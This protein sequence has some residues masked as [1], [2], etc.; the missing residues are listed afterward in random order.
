MLNVDTDRLNYAE[1]LMPPVHYHLQ[2]AIATTY[3]L[4]L[5][6]LLSIPVALFYSKSPGDRN[7]K[8]DSIEILDAIQ[9]TE[10]IVS[11]FC[12][13]GKIKIPEDYNHLFA[14]LENSVN[15]INTDEVRSSFHP[16]VW[17]LRYEHNDK[18]AI[19]YKIIV[20]SRNL[21]FDRSWDVAFFSDGE[22]KKNI[23]N[24]N[25]ELVDF[26]AFI[27]KQS[28]IEIPKIFIKDL[29]KVEF[30]IPKDVKELF[31]HPILQFKNA[32]FKKQY[33][34]PLEKFDF[35]KLLIISPF[36]DKS[37]LNRFTKQSGEKYLFSRKEE[38][39]KVEK[40]RLDKFT[41][42]YYINTNIVHGEDNI[43][44]ESI[45]NSLQ[46]LHAKVFVLEKDNNYSLY[47][48]SA[49]CSAPAFERNTEFMTELKSSDNKYS[50][51]NIKNTLLNQ[52]KDYQYFFE[53]KS[54]Q[55]ISKNDN[56]EESI[57]QLEFDII[58]GNYWGEA[59]R[60][61]ANTFDLKIN[62]DLKE[63]NSE[64]AYKIYLKPYNNENSFEIEVGKTG[65]ITFKN[66]GLNKLS[67]FIEIEVFEEENSILKILLKA[68]IDMPEERNESIFKSL[69]DSSDKFFKYLSFLITE[70]NTS[71]SDS[72]SDAYSNLVNSDVKESDINRVF[73]GMPVF[74]KLLIASSR[75]KHSLQ[76]V[77]KLI[78]RLKSD[79]KIIPKDFLKLWEVFNQFSKN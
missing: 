47:L 62:Y 39:D 40:E 67:S 8:T 12:Q 45:D 64:K 43:D 20:L 27:S 71:E 14:F 44:D 60:N 42:V 16:K 11:V 6:T 3:S 13:K 23:K 22:V 56:T 51:E 18:K 32:G 68:E 49:N 59:V 34:N 5:F 17:I 77:G 28:K 79:D 52:D 48:G 41:K 37:T 30:S 35:N 70:N 66:L 55:Q 74:E 19:I 38:L 50:V 73:Y 1:I 75:D 24:K 26:L 33:T 2:K 53:Y 46:N 58:S 61:K 54:P 63:W 7:T 15:E 21:T 29:Q 36:L 57:R 9:K 76:Q 10:D 69:V 78:E 72:I 25:K 31:F 65:F 4:D